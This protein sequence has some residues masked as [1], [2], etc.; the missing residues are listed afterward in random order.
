[1]LLAIDAGNT[2]TVLGLYPDDGSTD[3]IE[4]VEHWRISSNA[5][6]TGDEYAQ[7]I[8]QLL[9]MREKSLD[10]QLSGIAIA[11]SVPAITTAIRDLAARYFAS[12]PI[13]I[14][15][16]V[17]T[18]MPVRYDN[19][20]DV[21]PDRIADA[22][23]AFDLFGGPT[24]VVDFGTGTTFE[25]VSAEGEYLGGAIVPG[26][27]ISMDAL[28]ARAAILRRVELV[29][30]KNV[31]GRSTIE[32]IT[33]G[34]VYGYAALCDGMCDRVEAELGGPCTVVATGGLSHL[35]A[36]VS[37]RIDHHE[38]WLTLHGVRLVY[39]RNVEVATGS[40]D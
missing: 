18:G 21:G 6:R 7:L 1:M 4:P 32:S 8:G 20:R 37:R 33:S 36:P 5:Q 35:I 11:S 3:S 31:I 40:G 9:G 30:P 29:P 27:E 12:E 15:G 14:G 23:A 28:Y 26:I 24:I 16:G 34:A 17:K 38:P 39:F 19:P 25:A 2:E 22:I 10:Q 13:V